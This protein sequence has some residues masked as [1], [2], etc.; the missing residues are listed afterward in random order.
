MSEPLDQLVQTL[1]DDVEQPSDGGEATRLRIGRS[2]A[3]RGKRRRVGRVLLLAACF[4]ASTALAFYVT[5]SQLFSESKTS[6]R[7]SVSAPPSPVPP[8]AAS[9]AAPEAAPP[10]SLPTAEVEQ[11][12]SQAP[13]A[14][15]ARKSSIRVVPS[16]PSPRALSDAGEPQTPAHDP[17]S[18]RALYLEAHRL[19]FRG[20]PQRALEAWQAFLAT[21]PSGPWALEARYNRG[22]VLVRLGHVAEARQ[23][24]EPFARGEHGGF[25]Q[26]EAQRLLKELR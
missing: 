25:R 11:P 8:T 23:A 1:R 12:S 13:R 24:L 7:R 19:H 10:A 20:A 18:Q 17:V 6:P 22:V 5:G 2:F 14:R 26:T 15:P 21:E 9:E 16:G 3:V 4:I